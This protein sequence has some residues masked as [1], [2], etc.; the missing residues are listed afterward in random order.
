MQR[1]QL[2]QE[3]M[4]EDKVVLLKNSLM[5]KQPS[6][7]SIR[8]VIAAFRCAVAN[9]DSAKKQ[10]DDKDAKKKK[11]KTF[12]KKKRILLDSKYR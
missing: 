9:I 10:E 3:K 11:K 5:Q 4:T 7:T 12:A 8:N 6:L 2:F 1:F